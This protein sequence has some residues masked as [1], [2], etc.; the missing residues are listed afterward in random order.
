MPRFPPTFALQGINDRLALGGWN[1]MATYMFR[2]YDLRARLWETGYDDYNHLWAEPFL[3]FTLRNNSL[4]VIRL[5]DSEHQVLNYTE[6]DEI[7]KPQSYV[8]DDA[9]RR[10]LSGSQPQAHAT[11]ASAA[12]GA[13]DLTERLAR[14]LSERSGDATA[15]R[16]RMSELQRQLGSVDVLEEA[17]FDDATGERLPLMA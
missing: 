3:N 17:V 1:G 9:T 10:R 2:W 14:Q 8:G 11:S 15:L 6:F 4:S 16:Q 5:V 7:P 13:L 12:V